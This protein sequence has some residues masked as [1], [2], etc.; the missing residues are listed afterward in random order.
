[1]ARGPCYRI[2][3]GDVPWPGIH[4]Q[5]PLVCG[6][7][8]FLLVPGP[9]SVQARSSGGPCGPIPQTYAIP[10]EAAHVYYVAPG[11]QRLL[12]G[13]AGGARTPGAFPF[14]TEIR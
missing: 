3:H 7:L 11:L 2:G 6:I 14:R 4:R 1:M 5:T 9:A 12:G 8:L 10:D 13:R